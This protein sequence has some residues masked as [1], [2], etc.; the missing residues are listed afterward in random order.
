MEFTAVPSQ[1]A[2]AM[3][4]CLLGPEGL[5]LFTCLA[6]EQPGVSRPPRLPSITSWQWFSSLSSRV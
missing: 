6:V 4:K 1:G 5:C 3:F 2:L